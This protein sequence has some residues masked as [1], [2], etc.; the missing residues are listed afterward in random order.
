[1]NK[2]IK[3]SLIIFL[4]LEFVILAGFLLLDFECDVIRILALCFLEFSLFVSMFS[5]I[6]LLKKGKKQ[7]TLYYTAGIVSVTTIYQIAAIISTLSAKA[8]KNNIKGFLFLELVINA[9]MF[10]LCTLISSISAHIGKSNEQ[11][12]EKQN[13]GD[14]NRSK[15]GGF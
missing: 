11:T 10:I 13:N 5:T 8:F 14:Y 6:L 7:D 4:T 9:L 2:Q 15:R 1:M 12:L 3:I